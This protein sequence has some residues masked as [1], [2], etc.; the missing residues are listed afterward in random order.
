[1]PAQAFVEKKIRVPTAI[2]DAV[3]ERMKNTVYRNWTE[4]MRH[5]LEEW[6]KKG[7]TK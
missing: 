2:Y 5:L 7:D 6:I 3:E 1:M 4:L